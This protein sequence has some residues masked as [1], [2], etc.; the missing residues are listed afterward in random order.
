MS[1]PKLLK[2]F[3]P[4]VLLLSV[5]FAQ[6]QEFYVSG[7]LG[8]SDPD[9]VDNEGTFTS[10]FTTG[11]VTG[12]TPP[13][14]LPSGTPIEWDT[15]LDTGDLWALSIG[16]QLNENFRAELEWNWTEWDVDKHTG[17]TAGG[18]DLTDIDAGVL[19]SGNTGDLGVTVGNLVADGNGSIESNTIFV[20]GYYDFAN[21][22]NLTPYLGLGVGYRQLDIDYRPGGAV[23]IDDDDSALAYQASAGVL[24]EINESID[25]LAAV[26][27]IAGEEVTVDSSLLPAELDIE[28][29]DFNYRVGLKWNF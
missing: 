21:D 27:Y 9:D 12:V 6:A 3:C 16:W 14:T 24:F 20:N 2:T 5:G 13:L 29:E 28:P 8:V 26:N 17:V 25:L 19:I 1:Y 11:A 10:S 4:A 22:S 18:I 15:E 23:I 7:A